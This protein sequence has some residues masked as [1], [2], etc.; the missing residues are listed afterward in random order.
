MSIFGDFREV[1][2]SEI[3]KLA[4]KIP[5]MWYVCKVLVRQNI[6]VR[7]I[8]IAPAPLFLLSSFVD[9]NFD[10]TFHTLINSCNLNL[11]ATGNTCWQIS[12]GIDPG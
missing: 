4:R 12:Q 7:T 8:V 6:N 3:I 2:N 11:I 10:L 9:K 5:D 1:A